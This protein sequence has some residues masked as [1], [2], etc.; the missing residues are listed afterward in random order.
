M[1]R[2]ESIPAALTRR[3]VRSGARSSAPRG[4][5]ATKKIVFSFDSSIAD[6]TAHLFECSDDLLK[7]VKNARVCGGMHLRTSIEHGAELG[8][9]V[10]KYVLRNNFQPLK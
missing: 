4:Y 3:S 6:T 9:E 10:A 8:K 5:Y 1:G 7:E 2:G